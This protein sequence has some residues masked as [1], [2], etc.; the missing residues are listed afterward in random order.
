MRE[1][2]VLHA[3]D[4]HD[5]EL[6]A[7]RGVESHQGHDSAVLGGVGNGVGVGDEGDPLE[8]VGESAVGLIGLE[9]TGHSLELGEVLHARLVL[10]V[11]AG[12]EFGEVARLLEH[13]LQNGARTRPRLDEGPKISHQGDEGLDLR[14]RPCGD[15][16]GLSGPR[17]RRAERDSFTLREHLDARLGAIADATP[18][19]VE[20]APQRDVVVGVG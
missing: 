3:R 8:E 18:W 2:A 4:E 10:R 5:G 1:D 9:L 12:H 19:R 14:Q 11:G 6:Q 15:T 20:N 16:G 17:Q 7:L 13:R